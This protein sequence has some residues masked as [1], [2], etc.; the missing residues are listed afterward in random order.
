MKK[1]LIKLLFSTIVMLNLS[2][3]YEIDENYFQ[4]NLGVQYKFQ[5]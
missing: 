1:I 4:Y 3:S 5:Q 2:Q